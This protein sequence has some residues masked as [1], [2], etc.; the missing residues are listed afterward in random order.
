MFGLLVLI[1]VMTQAP[2]A[3][4]AST[5]TTDA[6][7]S[8]NVG[9]RQDFAIVL[10]AN[11][12]TGYSWSI[13]SEPDPAVAVA[14]DNQFIGPNTSIPGAPG[15]E[16]FRFTSTGAGQTSVGFV[17]T[18]PFEPDAPPAQSVDVQITV[19]A[20]DVPVQLPALHS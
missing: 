2:S 15:R 5:T 17:Y 13:A 4:M 9:I 18:R 20:S 8:I 3:C 12:T 7:Q 14:L 1:L 11:P 6:A 10:A 19:D 16:C